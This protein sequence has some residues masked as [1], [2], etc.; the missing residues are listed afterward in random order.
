MN[1]KCLTVL[2]DML[3]DR[4]FT[5]NK[6]LNDYMQI[7]GNDSGQYV[8]IY[9]LTD[10]KISVKKMKD[11]KK[12][13]DKNIFN[14]LILIY[15]ESVTS[16][17]KQYLI[18]D[19]NNLHIQLF[20]EKELMINITKHELNPKFK[21]ISD[22]EKSKIVSKFNCKLNQFPYL[23][24]TDPISKYYA[25]LPGDLIQICRTSPT[26]GISIVYRLVV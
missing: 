9:F 5:D 20:S 19:F 23:L 8:L 13:I 15:K 7:S 1:P 6:K 14:T 17:A 12:E 24:S 11:V 16:F 22:D 25:Y 2:N 3:L 21:K 10:S 4:G 18:S 26:A